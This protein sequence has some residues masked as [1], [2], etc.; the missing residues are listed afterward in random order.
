MDAN[1][2][3]ARPSIGAIRLMPHLGLSGSNCNT[4]ALAARPASVL[5]SRVINLL[6][7]QTTREGQRDNAFRSNRP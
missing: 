5:K 1:V 4:R 3:W 7:G 6:N 2:C